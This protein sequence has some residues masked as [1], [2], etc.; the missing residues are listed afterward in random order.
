MSDNFAPDV[1]ILPIHYGRNRLLGADGYAH[2]RHDD[3]EPAKKSC[4][5]S[6]KSHSMIVKA[7]KEAEIFLKCRKKKCHGT[8]E[9]FRE[10]KKDVLHND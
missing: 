8:C 4:S 6:Y 2:T 3:G 1:G 10:K 9:Y 5:Y 7:R